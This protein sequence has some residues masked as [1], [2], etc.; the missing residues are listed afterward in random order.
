MTRLLPGMTATPTLSKAERRQAKAEAV[1]EKITSGSLEVHFSLGEPILARPLYFHHI[2]KTAGT[3]FRAGLRGFFRER[4]AA[5]LSAP[6]VKRALRSERR[7]PEGLVDLDRRA[8]AFGRV[9]L[10]ASHYTAALANHIDDPIVTFFREPEAH[11][12]SYV[13]FHAQHLAATLERRGVEAVLARTSNLQAKSLV[14]QWGVEL[15]PAPHAHPVAWQSLVDRILERF[16][17]FR[18]D[19]YDAA[20]DQLADEYRFTLPAQGAK[21]TG[22]YDAEA[23]LDAITA[24]D[25][26]DHLWFDRMIYERI[27]A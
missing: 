24:A 25:V 3:S 15:L 20:M 1:G 22:T 7:F 19:C 21:K 17:M 9:E 27:G 4:D 10:F 26:D 13:S 11:R 14:A 5:T 8:R 18:T 16:T 6:Q 12:R 23:L 2:P